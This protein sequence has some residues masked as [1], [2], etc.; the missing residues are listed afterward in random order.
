ME[1]LRDARLDLFPGA[2]DSA[3]TVAI[4]NGVK[5]VQAS[6]YGTPGISYPPGFRPSRVLD[7]DPTTSWQVGGQPTTIP[8]QRLRIVLDAPITT[9]QVNLLQPI[10]GTRG[11]YITQATMRFDGGDPVRRRLTPASRNE[12]GAGQTVK[13]PRRTFTTFTIEIDR[14]HLPN[15]PF[16]DVSARPGHN[17]RWNTSNVGFAEIRLRDDRPGATDV[18]VDEIIRMPTDLLAAAGKE[19]LDHPLVIAIARDGLVAG[20][21]TDPELDVIRQF[22]LPTARDFGL[23]GAA[24]L[25]VTA[26]DNVIDQL[27]GI[28]PA[29][30]GGIDVTSTE[31]LA[32]DVRVRGSAALDGDLTTSWSTPFGD[33]LDQSIRVTTPA[34]ITFDHLDL[35]VVNDRRHS[36][37]R[38]IEITSD[39]GTTRLVDLPRVGSQQTNRAT[40]TTPVQFDPISGQTFTFTI[41]AVREIKR[42]DYQT[43]SRNVMPAAIAE[44]GIP[45][46]APVVAPASIPALCR[47]DLV[48]MDGRPVPVRISGSSAAA[49]SQETLNLALC[50]PGDIVE[51]ASGKHVLRTAKGPVSGVDFDRIV[52]TSA[53]GG[54]AASISQVVATPES[55]PASA[56]PRVRVLKQDSTSMTVRIDETSKPFWMVLG[57]SKNA[58]WEAK[59]DGR[60]L[61][62]SQLV[63][64]YANGWLVKPNG[65][66]PITIKLEWVPQKVVRIGLLVSVLGVL[67]CLAI[68][69]VAQLR[70]RR[71]RKAARAERLAAPDAPVDPL[72]APMIL[73][74]ELTTPLVARGR[75]PSTA[76]IVLTT[77][78]AGLAASAIVRP[79]C[80]LLVGPA[81]LLVLLRPRWRAVLSLFP[82][83]ALG[84]CGLYVA[85]VQFRSHYP[86]GLEWPGAFWRARTL[87]WLAIIF[88]AADVLVSL[89]RH[90]ESQPEDKPDEQSEE[91][92]EPAPSP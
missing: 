83:I 45:G 87:G 54:A 66:G 40:A 18:R 49:V 85:V 72:L 70:V 39:D 48:T 64:G 52:L 33:V 37:P 29:A 42:V 75:R 4:L 56:S 91:E 6:S 73:Q 36:V 82:F 19:S 38:A 5:S 86:T 57:Q 27:V 62:E 67:A 46:V 26:P 41:R 31:H 1:D 43:L 7:G 32:G 69:G 58:G 92:P 61:G 47:S 81:V 21:A 71:R 78:F 63:D 14:I 68:I 16:A 2:T 74:P 9:D 55:S 20:P 8:G 84:L 60:D 34:P 65:P 25:D 13:F 22:A 77:L 30:A 53:A 89:A 76:V 23:G 35:N 90:G 80:G 28:P 88:L 11:K 12:S 59:A 51:L 10:T 15:R 24:R 17:A 79:W 50:E 44:L 3:R